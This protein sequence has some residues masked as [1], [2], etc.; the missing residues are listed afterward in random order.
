MYGSA[1]YLRPPSVSGQSQS[2]I[3]RGPGDP[4]SRGK[5]TPKSFKY[6]GRVAAVLLTSLVVLMGYGGPTV[7]GVL[8][9]R[10]YYYTIVVIIIV[11][12]NFD[13]HGFLLA[14]WFNACLCYGCHAIQGRV[15]FDGM[16]V[17]G[18]VKFDHG[19]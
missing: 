18:A 15:F 8:I 5:F 13:Y 10:Y 19:I 16:D 12:G 17:T 7:A 11:L 3:Q 14:D 6:N 2:S 9:V 4:G 1:A